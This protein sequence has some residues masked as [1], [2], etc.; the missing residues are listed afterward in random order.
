MAE[1]TSVPA[2]DSQPLLPAGQ[3]VGGRYRI[4]RRLG[5]GGNGSVFEA[6]DQQL[7]RQVAVK[8]LHA[9]EEV[10]RRRMLD[11]ADKL[12]R[13][14]HPRVLTIT[15]KGEIGDSIFIVTELLK[16]KTL[17]TWMDELR[18]R[19]GTVGQPLVEPGVAVRL[20]HAIGLALAA[21][22]EH[23]IVHRD[24]KPDN[25]MFSLSSE[26][27]G[28]VDW[29]KLIDFGLAAGKGSKPTLEGTPYYVSPEVASLQSE[30]TSATDLY[31]LGCILFELLEGEPPYD[32]TVEEICAAHVQAP[33]PRTSTGLTE[34]DD[35]ISGLM[36]KAPK[37][38][39]QHAQDV[40]RQLERFG[41]L[42]DENKTRPGV[43]LRSLPT[44]RL[45]PPP[46]KVETVTGP[47]APVAPVPSTGELSAS[48]KPDRRPL[49]VVALLALFGLGALLLWPGKPPPAPNTPPEPPPLVVRP[50]DPPLEPVAVVAA[51]EDAGAPEVEDP[52]VPLSPIRHVEAPRP[53]LKDCTPDAKWRDRMER[54]LKELGSLAAPNDAHAATY[55][56]LE[57]P[58]SRLIVNAQ[59]Q[60]Q[61]LKAEK[62]L[63]DLQFA[64]VG[65]R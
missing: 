60:E 10:A 12:A 45:P 23:G 46:A 50:P 58:L 54:T 52:L 28:T 3:I 18:R 59:D 62:L 55:D 43:D 8:V 32:G 14:H 64:I 15:D 22:H 38:R 56:R 1:A 34:L 36:Q 4:E 9:S 7:N 2:S 47:V 26:A 30:V 16:G 39:P 51:A 40:A 48:V 61:C 19:Q 41:A 17:T 57:P 20:G 25:I 6:V 53:K 24:L 27:A 5:R 11:E 49:I 65:T 44:Q 13:I 21:V 63:A 31:S 33:V 35:L 42:L 29:L 37:A